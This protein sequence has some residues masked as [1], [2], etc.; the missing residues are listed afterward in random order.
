[1]RKREDHPPVDS[2]SD[3]PRLIALLRSGDPVVFESVFRT[4]A[5]ALVD[6]SASYLQSRDAAEEIVQD[7]FPWLWANRHDFNPQS[8]LRPYFFSAVRNRSLNALRNDAT[9]AGAA[10]FMAHAAI[11]DAT[12]ADAELMA[13]DLEAAIEATVGSMPARCR[14]VFL[15]VRTQSLSYAEVAAILGIAPKTVAAHM[16]HAH[17]LL[18]ARLGPWL[19]G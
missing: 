3:E 9:A 4:Y 7:L 8:G 19:N 6:F 1:M 2:E 17:A 13:S 15:L 5:L 18:R 16:T 10:E 11:A 12:P 14:E